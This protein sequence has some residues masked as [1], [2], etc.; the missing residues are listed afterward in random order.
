MSKPLT[1]RTI[2]TRCA[3]LRIRACTACMIMCTTTIRLFALMSTAVSLLSPGRYLAW[4]RPKPHGRHR[5][6]SKT[7]ARWRQN[8]TGATRGSTISLTGW[9]K[10]IKEVMG[11]VTEGMFG[12]DESACQDGHGY[13]PG[14]ECCGAETGTCPLTDSGRCAIGYPEDIY[15]EFWEEAEAEHA[16]FLSHVRHGPDPRKSFAATGNMARYCVYA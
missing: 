15:E 2:S 9:L 1:R 8:S 10:G 7:S 6:T 4:T 12:D 16:R 5:R 3:M 14:E 11:D 13:Q